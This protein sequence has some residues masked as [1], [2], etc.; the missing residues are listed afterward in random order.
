M[1]RVADIATHRQSEKFAH[2]VIFQ[3]GAN[4]LSFIVKVFWTNETNHT[5]HQERVEYSR[6]AVRAHKNLGAATSIAIHFGT[7]HL[8]DDG[9]HEPVTELQRALDR[10]KERLR[11]WTLDAGEGRSQ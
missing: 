9:E 3:A 7:F 10:E 5:I 11:F 4:D 1:V 6:D 8:A 2:E